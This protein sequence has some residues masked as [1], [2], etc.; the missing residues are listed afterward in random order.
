MSFVVIFV[1]FLFLFCFVL[2][3]YLFIYILVT[4]LLLV[5]PSHSPSLILYS[6]E[7]VEGV[8]QTFPHPGTS[9]LWETGHFLFH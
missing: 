2:A 6:S 3:F 1:C 5:I 4:A 9:S 7:Q 8:P